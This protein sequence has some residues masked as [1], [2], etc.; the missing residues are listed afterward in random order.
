MQI[1]KLSTKNLE[2]LT[3]NNTF[4]CLLLYQITFQSKTNYI[5]SSTQQNSKQIIHFHDH[6]KRVSEISIQRHFFRPSEVKGLVAVLCALHPTPEGQNI[7]ILSRQG[8]NFKMIT[9]AKHEGYISVWARVRE[10]GVKLMKT[11]GIDPL[12]YYDIFEMLSLPVQNYNFL[13]L[14]NRWKDRDRV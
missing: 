1:I 8:Q 6:N 10:E 9:S 4:C 5:E 2:C 11:S 13:S 3:I 12:R 14:L 7:I